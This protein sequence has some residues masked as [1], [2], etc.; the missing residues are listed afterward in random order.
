MKRFA[1]FITFMGAFLFFSNYLATAQNAQLRAVFIYNF[2]KN[3]DWPPSNANAGFIIG[4]LGDSDIIDELHG[5]S[6][7]YKINNQNIIVKQFSTIDKL[8]KCNILFVPNSQSNNLAS[9]LSKLQNQSTLVIVDQEE[10]AKQGADINFTMQSGKLEFE[11]NPQNLEKR[12][13]KVSSKLLDLG[14]VVN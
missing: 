1:I 12:D 3:I 8:S 14:H 6:K 2:T 4:V 7:K 10:A 9:I 5:I 13:L 11:I